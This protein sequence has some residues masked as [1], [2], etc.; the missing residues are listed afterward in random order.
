VKA[1]PDWKVTAYARGDAEAVKKDLGVQRVENGDF[2]E[3]DK[4]KALSKEHDIAVNAGNSFTD[5]PIA[6]I[7]AGLRE[8]AG[9]A[10]GKL[11]HISGK[12]IPYIPRQ[13]DCLSFRKLARDASE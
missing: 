13:Y 2:S 1:H 6:A 4:I 12:S 10:K 3:F 7:V 9:E 11:L 5:A 8:H